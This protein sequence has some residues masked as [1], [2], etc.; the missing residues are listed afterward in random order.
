MSA[1]AVARPSSAGHRRCNKVAPRHLI[2]LLI[3]AVSALG[4]PASAASNSEVNITGLTDLSFGSIANLGTDNIRRESICLYAKNKPTDQY[5]ITANGSGTGGV[6]TLA[7][8]GSTL[9]YDVQWSAL[10]NQASGTQLTP[11]Q[12]LTG[13]LNSASD[14][15]CS[16]G[17]ATTA[18][19][20][21]ILRAAALSA[22]SAGAYS[23]TLTLLVAPD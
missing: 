12:P 13:Q 9:P 20:I 7:S 3:S 5:R 2:I 18:S 15:V 4:S 1:N 10:P 16:S 22:A 23:G 17:S 21:V 19:L 14:S 8:G 6:F 11:N